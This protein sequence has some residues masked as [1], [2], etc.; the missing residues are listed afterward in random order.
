MQQTTGARALALPLGVRRPRPALTGRG[1]FGHA[2]ADGGGDAAAL[3]KLIYLAGSG[4][5]GSTLLERVL[6]SAEAIAA[7]GEL[8]CLWRLPLDELVCACGSTV[9][10]DPFWMTVLRRARIDQEELRRLAHLES[11]VARTGVVARNRFSLARLAGLPQAAEYVELQERIYGA[12]A[13]ELGVEA[14]VDSSKAGPRAWLMATRPNTTI[15]HL[16]RDPTDVLLSW[17]SHKFDQGLGGDMPRRRVSVAAREWLKAEVMLRR[18]GRETPVATITHKAFCMSPRASTRALIDSLEL[19]GASTP[20]WTG[21]NRFT[22]GPRYHSV[23]GNPDRFHTGEVKIDHRPSPRGLDSPTRT[24]CR[25]VGGLLRHLCPPPPT[26]STVPARP[27]GEADGRG[28][29]SPTASS[30]INDCAS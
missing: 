26:I 11:S 13:T 21:A 23:N 6:H 16:Y 10:E 1:T 30:D 29:G 12:V 2:T 20:A 5:S 22:T 4:R 28:L 27:Q 3:V 18:L 9:S 17:R 7:V 19:R 8:H 15:C 24:T 14:I 25:L